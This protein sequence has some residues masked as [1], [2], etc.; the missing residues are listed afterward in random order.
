MENN[1]TYIISGECIKF[2]LDALGNHMFS[3]VNDGDYCEEYNNDDVIQAID[4]L[5]QEV[6]NNGK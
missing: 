3:S 5:Q 4:M 6:D 2:V 1:R